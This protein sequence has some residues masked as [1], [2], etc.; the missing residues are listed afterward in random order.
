MP[1]AFIYRL[2]LV[3]AAG[4]QWLGVANFLFAGPSY[5]L[6]TLGQ[7]WMRVMVCGV[8]PIGIHGRQILHLQFDERGS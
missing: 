2:Q 5:S 8:R 1:M 6:Q 4:F 3:F 7:D